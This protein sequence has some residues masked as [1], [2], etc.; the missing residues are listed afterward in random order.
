MK[1]PKETPKKITQSEA[2]DIILSR[3]PRGLFFLQEGAS[4]VGIDNRTG[5]AW[6][7]DFPT[8]EMCLAWL[9]N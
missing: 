5:D 2:H 8:R 9:A 7:E 1:N 3:V 4:W 6:T